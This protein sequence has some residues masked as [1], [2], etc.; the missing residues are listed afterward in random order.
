MHNDSGNHGTRKMVFKYSRD[1]NVIIAW[2]RYF[3]RS[4][5]KANVVCLV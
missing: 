5:N 1:V 4:T 3:D 2:L